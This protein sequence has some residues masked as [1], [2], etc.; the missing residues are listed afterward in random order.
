MNAPV[1]LGASGRVSRLVLARLRLRPILVARD[2]GADGI[3][4][5]MDQPP[6]DLPQAAGR[7]LFDFSGVTPR[8]GGDPGRNLLLA[9]QA[10]VAAR[11]WGAA[12]LFL[13][14]SSS[15]VGA[16][17]P[18]GVD[19]ARAHAPLGAYGRAMAAV[20]RWADEAVHAVPVTVLRLGNVAG[21]GAPFDS[22]AAPGPVRLDRFANG[23][24]PLR[25]YAGPAGLAKLVVT[26]TER[27]RAGQPLPRLLNVAG[28]RPTAMADILAHLGKPVDWTAA[29]AE[30]VACAVL[31][32]T[33]LEALAP[34][35]MGDGDAGALVADV[36]G[37]RA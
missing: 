6:P 7:A 16:T 25:S 23:Q 36:M 8:S 5:D 26:L 21:A 10:A 33:R 34:G 1:W 18:G 14:S 4:W 12:H 28:Q 27:V 2:P 17:G 9:R 22:A 11:R 31:D 35:C 30:A 13:T 3:C 24:G 19:E 15:V 20:E 29:P 37:A 32:T